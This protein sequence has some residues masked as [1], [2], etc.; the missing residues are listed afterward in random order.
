MLA[1]ERTVEDSTAVM[2]TPRLFS[3]P[4]AALMAAIAWDEGEGRVV[5][6]NLWDEPA[7][8]FIERVMPLVEIWGAVEQ[9]GQAWSSSR[10][11]LP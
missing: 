4:P 1:P 7:D 10:A 5:Q 8:F 11:L 9:A 2:P 3:E 6:M